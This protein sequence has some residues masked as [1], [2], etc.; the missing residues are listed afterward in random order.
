M[1]IAFLLLLLIPLVFFF[2]GERGCFRPSTFSFFRQGGTLHGY[3]YGR[4]TRQYVR[5]LLAGLRRKGPHPNGVDRWLMDRYHG[6]VLTTDHA[7]AIVTLDR[8][9]PRQDLEQIIPFPLARDL[10]LA[11]PPDIVLYECACRQIRPDRCQPTAVCMVIGKPITDFILEHRPQDARRITQQQALDILE[12]EH[13]RGHVHAAWF[14]DAML[15]RFYAICNCCKC[16][17]GGMQAMRKGLSLIARSGFVAEI[18]RELCANCDDCVLA[19][20][21]DAL[22]KTGEG[23]RRDWDRCMGCG[24]CEGVCA[25]GAVSLARD[26]RKGLPLDVRALTATAPKG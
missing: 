10:V 15:N 19:C 23:I 6:K 3:F 26:E 13:R 7:R 4:W 5:A 22:S 2:V 8:D 9:I 24:A 18:D 20:P 14:K 11:G 16:C 1:W 12:A 21:F 25:T 17:C